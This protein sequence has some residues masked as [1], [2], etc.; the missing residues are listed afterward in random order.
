MTTEELASRRVV[1]GLVGLFAYMFLTGQG[2]FFFIWSICL[3]LTTLFVFLLFSLPLKS[4][5]AL[6]QGKH[7]RQYG[8]KGG[9]NYRHLLTEV[10]EGPFNAVNRLYLKYSSGIS[11]VLQ[12]FLS[13]MPLGYCG[14]GRH[15][16]SC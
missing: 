7:N 11:S 3:E 6:M 1:H 10:E 12:L 14:L 8:I 16:P 13:Q 9:D 5:F 2:V 15:I 4:K